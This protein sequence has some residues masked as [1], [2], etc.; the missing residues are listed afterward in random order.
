MGRGSTKVMGIIEPA[1]DISQKNGGV[2]TV[3]S[4]G[5]LSDTWHVFVRF[6]PT[7]LLESCPVQ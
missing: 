3:N 1:C 2:K 4:H 6:K 5:A 7:Q